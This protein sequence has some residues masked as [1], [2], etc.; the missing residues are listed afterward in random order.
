LTESVDSDGNG[1][2]NSITT[3]TYED[4]SIEQTF[5]ELTDVE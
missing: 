3:Y 5:A 2:P 4:S 1:M